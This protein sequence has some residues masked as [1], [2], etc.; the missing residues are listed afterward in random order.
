MGKIGYELIEEVFGEHFDHDDFYS[1]RDGDL[2]GFELISDDLSYNSGWYNYYE[3]TVKDTNT[4]K[5]YSFEYNQH[6]SDNVC[7][8]GLLL[9]TFKEIEE[10]IVYAAFDKFMDSAF[11]LAEDFHKKNM[12]TKPEQNFLNAFDHYIDL[13][14]EEDEE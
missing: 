6:T 13:V 8:G 11:E 5:K 12:L 1:L 3:V 14:V 2:E 7:D 9:G 4:G 10:D